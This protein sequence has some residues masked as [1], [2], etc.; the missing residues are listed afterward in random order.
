MLHP[1]YKKIGL[2]TAHTLFHFLPLA[3]EMMYRICV[4]KKG[5]SSVALSR[6]YNVNQKTAVNFKRKVQNSM[7]SSELQPLEGILHVDKFMYGGVAN[8]CQ[9][10]SGKS[11]KLKVCVPLEIIPNKSKKKSKRDGVMPFQLK[12]SLKAS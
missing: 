4:N 2:P 5:I 8:G 6:E 9:G 1:Q 7:Q 12:T 11:N 10:R 3:F